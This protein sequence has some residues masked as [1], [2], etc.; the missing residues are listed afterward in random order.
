MRAQAGISLSNADKHTAADLLLRAV[1]RAR[2]ALMLTAIKSALCE[3]SCKLDFSQ[4]EIARMLFQA[5]R[6]RRG[7]LKWPLVDDSSQA[8]DASEAV[9]LLEERRLEWTWSK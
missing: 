8:Q 5:R 7:Y 1:R 6:T 9:N 3:K 4:L 2:T